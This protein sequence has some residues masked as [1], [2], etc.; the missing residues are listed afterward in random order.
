MLAKNFPHFRYKSANLDGNSCTAWLAILWNVAS[1]Y[2][3]KLHLRSPHFQSYSLKFPRVRH[4]R[5]MNVFIKT[6]I[7]WL[8][9]TFR[10]EI[11]RIVLVI[12]FRPSPSFS[13]KIRNIATG[14]TSQV[15]ISCHFSSLLFTSMCILTSLAL[16]NWKANTIHIHISN[17]S[18]FPF[19]SLHFSLSLLLSIERQTQ[20]IQIY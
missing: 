11:W 9:T 5:P 6:L 16:I 15:I 7:S 1:Q 3:S 8:S 10:W 20:Y 13:W 18:T 12:I 2:K 14:E 4:V 17:N 19:I